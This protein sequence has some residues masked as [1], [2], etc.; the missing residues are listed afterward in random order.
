MKGRPLENGYYSGRIDQTYSMFIRF[1]PDIGECRIVIQNHTRETLND[2]L[3]YLSNRAIMSYG[4]NDDFS[5][6]EDNSIL[7]KQRNPNGGYIWQQGILSSDSRT[8]K[9]QLVQRDATL[10]AP[11]MMQFH[12]YYFT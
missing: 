7:I 12:D 9:L 2:M 10:S 1:F 4:N 5:S 6:H 8:I 3:G 11:L